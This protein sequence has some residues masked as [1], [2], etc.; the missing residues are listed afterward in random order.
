M[1]LLSKCGKIQNFLFEET[2]IKGLYEINP[3]VSHDLRGSF[4]KDYSKNI[5][6][7]NEINHEVKEVFYTTSKKGVLRGLHFQKIKQQPKLIRCLHGNIFDV[8]VD[9][10][11]ESPTFKKWLSFDL[12]ESNLKEI[13][14]PPRCAH[15][16]LALEESTVSYK[17]A[18]IFYNEHDGGIIWNDPD[19][20]IDWPIDR[21]GGVNNII[22]SDKDKGLPYLSEIDLDKDSF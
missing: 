8:V 9:L 10:R 6:E 18:E 14:I 21:I 11:V 13:L 19:L 7:A 3:F 17:C 16:F 5:F 12:T 20:D 15:G 22:L 2:A 4:V 1:S